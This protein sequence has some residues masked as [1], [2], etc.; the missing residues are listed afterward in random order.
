MRQRNRAKNSKGASRKVNKVF[1]CFSETDLFTEYQSN[2]EWEQNNAVF[3]FEW[4]PDIVLK[5]LGTTAPAGL[6]I[7]V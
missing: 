3:I 7:L 2:Q 6:D 1:A 4:A 5:K